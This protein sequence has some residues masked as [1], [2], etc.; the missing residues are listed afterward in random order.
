MRIYIGN[1]SYDT[2]EQSLRQAFENYGEVSEV[3]MIMDRDSGRPKGFAFIEMAAQNEA[4]AAIDG[5]N[6]QELDGRTIKVN[7]AR[8]RENRDGGRGRRNY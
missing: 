2:T 5:L 6:E 4:T 8:E 3:K 7:E 1:L